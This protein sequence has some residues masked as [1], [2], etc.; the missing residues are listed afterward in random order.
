MKFSIIAI[1]I[2]VLSITALNAQISG[3]SPTVNLDF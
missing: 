1:I 2:V 3:Y